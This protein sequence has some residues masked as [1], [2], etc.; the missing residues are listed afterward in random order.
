LD[1][2]LLLTESA[3]GPVAGSVRYEYDGDFRVASVAVNGLPAVILGYDRDGLPV[4][5]GDLVLTRD[6]RHGLVT[7][8]TLAAVSTM[9]AYDGFGDLQTIAAAHGGTSL[10]SLELD[11]DRLGRIIE[12]TETV[13][14][15]THVHEYRYD[16]AGPLRQVLLDGTQVAFYAYDGNGNRLSRTAPARVL[17]GSFDDQD[18]LLQL[19]DVVYDYS[20]S[21]ELRTRTVGGEVTTYEYDPLGQLLSVAL[22]DGRMIEYLID[23]LNRRT[24]KKVD[25][26]MVH[27][28]LYRDRLRP[29]AELDAAGNL[30][31][32]FVY[33]G[34]RNAPDYLIRGAELYRLITDHL[35]SP[36]LVVNAT[37]GEVAQRLD[38]DEFGKVVADSNPG[39]QPFG[40][41]GGLYDPDTGLVRFGFRDYDAE[42]GRWTSKDPLL[43]AGGDTNLYA[44]V[45][46]DPVNRRDELGLRPYKDTYLTMEA[47]AEAALDEVLGESIALQQEFG[48]LIYQNHDGT[49]SYTEARISL[50]GRRN[51]SGARTRSGGSGLCPKDIPPV[52]DYHTHPFSDGQEGGENFSGNDVLH[53]RES[54]T[55]GFL[56][57][58]SGR[59][60]VWDLVLNSSYWLRALPLSLELD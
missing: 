21:G 17:E 52:G 60:L 18:R 42:T 6:P 23:G 10:Y 31:S 40:F 5:A 33:A 4:R 9:R 20:A 39:F 32:Q 35:G 14:G 29:A 16:E 30:V 19:G 37:T 26:S 15:E 13:L 44:Y 47:A 12:A 41:A 24:A 45:A 3:A 8:T 36:R 1:G 57:T 54:G 27:A 38:Y 28:F 22:P 11:R 2:F 50:P 56:G 58:P 51:L 59:I 7:Q 34:R 49:F 55:T 48:G 25:G 46:N 53:Y 43:V